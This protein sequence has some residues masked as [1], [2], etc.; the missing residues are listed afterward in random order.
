[1]IGRYSARVMQKNVIF[2]EKEDERKLYLCSGT[3]AY[4]R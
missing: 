1:M 2:H 4:I 3:Y